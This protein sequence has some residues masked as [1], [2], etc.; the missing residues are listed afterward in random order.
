MGDL[1]RARQYYERALK[2]AEKR[3]G[4]KHPSVAGVL[5]NI[6]T[7]EEREHRYAASAASYE[8]AQAIYEQWP[9]ANPRNVADAVFGVARISYARGDK[10]R[11][12]ALYD[13]LLGMADQVAESD[14][15]LALEILDKYSNL[16]RESGQADKLAAIEAKQAAIRARK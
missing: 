9:G 1:P 8:R 5:L 7:L 12:A 2:V 4:P 6:G 11:A 10:A 3:N 13:R 15:P 14:R 16:L